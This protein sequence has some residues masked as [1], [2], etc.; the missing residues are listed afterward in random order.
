MN[1]W[2]SEGK[3][4]QRQNRKDRQSDRHVKETIHQA[5]ASCPGWSCKDQ[6]SLEPHRVWS[7]KS[8]PGMWRTGLRATIYEVQC[9]C[10]SWWVMDS[11]LITPPPPVFRNEQKPWW[12]A[13]H[14]DQGLMHRAEDTLYGLQALVSSYTLCSIENTLFKMFL[15]IKWNTLLLVCPKW[16]INQWSKNNIY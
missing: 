10:L 8:G 1:P 5:H 6:F 13:D 2:K 3:S 15:I 4:A 7:S 11:K 16:L 12:G 9:E 14:R